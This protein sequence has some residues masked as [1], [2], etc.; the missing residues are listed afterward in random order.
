MMRIA[1]L[2]THG[3]AGGWWL[4]RSIGARRCTWNSCGAAALTQMLW[5][6]GTISQ[7]H[8]WEKYKSVG[9][10]WTQ[11]TNSFQT[12]IVTRTRTQAILIWF[13][14]QHV[15]IATEKIG[16]ELAHYWKMSNSKPEP[17]SYHDVVQP[18]QCM[19]RGS[20]LAP[21]SDDP[22]WHFVLP[23]SNLLLMKIIQTSKFY[24]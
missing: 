15:F 18:S 21:G 14:I 22:Q 2:W 1:W 19:G 13:S 24:F 7:N 9:C 6:D 23:L 16:A 5:T 11:L 8:F 17:L 12:R 3:G 10:A 20:I 4:W